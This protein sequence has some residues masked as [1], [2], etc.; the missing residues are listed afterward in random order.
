MTD[1]PEKRWQ[2]IL[3]LILSALGIL[4][5]LLQAFG[6]GIYW[7]VSLFDSQTGTVENISNNLQTLYRYFI[8]CITHCVPC[9]IIEIDNINCWYSNF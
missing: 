4:Y 6:I 8:N 5:F 7:L 1:S 3:A 2:T 9:R